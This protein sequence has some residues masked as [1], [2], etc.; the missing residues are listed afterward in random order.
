MTGPISFNGA[1]SSA[2]LD[3][4]DAYINVM[5]PNAAAIQ[6]APFGGVGIEGLASWGPVDVPTMWSPNSLLFGVPKVR[7][8]DTMTA[9][10]IVA[11]AQQAAGLGANILISRRTD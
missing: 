7:A 2:L 8:N 9:A 1:F 6:P 10:Y 11:Q 3:V 5:P 4:P